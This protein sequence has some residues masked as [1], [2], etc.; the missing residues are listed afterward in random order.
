[1]KGWEKARTRDVQSDTPKKYIFIRINSKR[2]ERKEWKREKAKERE[3][4]KSIHFA[5]FR[6]N[7]CTA[8]RTTF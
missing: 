7:F 1:M 6:D 4:K 5:H 2:D 8:S 3:R